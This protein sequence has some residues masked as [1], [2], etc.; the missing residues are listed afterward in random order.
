MLVI[1]I[2]DPYLALFEQGF[3]TLEIVFEISVLVRAYVI[4]LYICENTVV[5]NKSRCSV[6]HKS[7]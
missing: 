5:K 7:L 6:Q 3:L 1:S 2:Y 4:R